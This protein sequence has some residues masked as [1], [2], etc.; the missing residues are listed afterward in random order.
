MAYDAKPGWSRVFVRPGESARHAT[1]R[2]S[3]PAPAPP[4]GPSVGAT[5]EDF[6]AAVDDGSAR[7]RYGRTFTSAAA[8]ELH[9]NLGGHVAEAL[10]AM[11]LNGVRRREVEALVYALGDAGLSRRRL[12]AL[13]KSVR[14]LFDYA[15]ERE[16]VVDNPALRIALPDEDETEQPTGEAGSPGRPAHAATVVDHVISMALRV[17]TLGFL[18][19]AVTFLAESLIG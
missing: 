3:R 7:D 1:R 9:W 17:A 12:R 8:V 11:S 2:R 5:I 6:L 4:A 15:V 14:A 19:T 10:G 18:L 16:L 13:A